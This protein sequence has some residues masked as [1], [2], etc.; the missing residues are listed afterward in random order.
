MSAR[1]TEPGTLIG[2]TELQLGATSWVKIDQE[3]IDRF[4][5]AT[6]DH[7]WI[8][9][10]LTR[11]AT[12]PFGATIAHGHLT[13]SLLP[14]LLSELLA[15]EGIALAI[16][17]GFDRVRFVQ[18][19][20]SGSRVRATGVLVAAESSGPGVRAHIRVTIEIEGQMKPAL[21]ADALAIYV[22]A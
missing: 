16:N 6:D 5:D 4:A 7:Q 3:M 11:A 9:V 2:V 14:K 20:V 21:V 1:F 15:V 12:G 13:L 22:P 17:A 19:V 8:H 10:D 18:P